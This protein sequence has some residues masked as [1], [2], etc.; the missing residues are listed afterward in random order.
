MIEKHP[1]PKENKG[2]LCNFLNKKIKYY[3]IERG[4]EWTGGDVFDDFC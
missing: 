3:T 2:V 4:Y 1:Y